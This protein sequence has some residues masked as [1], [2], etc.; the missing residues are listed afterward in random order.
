MRYLK[1]MNGIYIA[2]RKNCE[3]K[4]KQQILFQGL[5]AFLR[6]MSFGTAQAQ[7]HFF[8]VVF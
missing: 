7:I 4:K 1:N 6:E 8:T 3:Q 5:C 2:F